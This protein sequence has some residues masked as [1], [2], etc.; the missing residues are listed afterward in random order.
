MARTIMHYIR[1]KKHVWITLVGVLIVLHIYDRIL[2]STLIVVENDSQQLEAAQYNPII[3]QQKRQQKLQQQHQKQ[4]KSSATKTTPSSIPATR[5]Q[6]KKV[7][8][9]P[10]YHVVFSTSCSLQQ[11]WEDRKSVV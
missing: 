5:A 8:R 11:D 4:R 7:D 1:T 2:R 3:Q 6:E 10:A 9:D